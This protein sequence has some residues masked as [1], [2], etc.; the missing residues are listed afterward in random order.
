MD[1]EVGNRRR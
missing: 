1:G